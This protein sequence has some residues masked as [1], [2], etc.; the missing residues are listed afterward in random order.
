MRAR[1]WV[2]NLFVV[3]TIVSWPYSADAVTISFRE[4][5][6]GGNG[7]EVFPQPPTPHTTVTT[8]LG[9]CVG[10]A[11]PC[12]LGQANGTESASIDLRVPGGKDALGDPDNGTF[13][14]P[15]R[16]RLPRLGPPAPADQ[17]LA[18]ALLLEKDAFEADISDIVE[19]RFIWGNGGPDQISI[20]FMSDSPEN[21]LG[22]IPDGFVFREVEANRFPS[23]PPPPPLMRNDIVLNTKFFTGPID[24][25][26]LQHPYC[27]N[28]VRD[29]ATG[30]IIGGCASANLP[31]GW[32]ISAQSD[33]ETVPEPP[34][35]ALLVIGILGLVFCRWRV[36]RA[37][38]F[39]F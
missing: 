38:R 11:P 16:T 6:G 20:K 18:R 4:A 26:D 34:T 28:P 23:T 29:R 5:E 8:D 30:L 22:H 3:A 1:L 12:V 15:D 24:N 2:V 17:H 14:D 33:P 32:T 25:S 9:S 13:L 35:L 37:N 19:L 7:I 31:A 36:V 21:N 10:G 39:S 27:Q